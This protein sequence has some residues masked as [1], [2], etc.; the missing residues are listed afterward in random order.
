MND[1][2]EKLQNQAETFKQETKKKQ[3]DLL[4]KEKQIQQLSENCKNLERC[5][6]EFTKIRDEEQ[7]KSANSLEE[8]KVG[9][10]CAVLCS[11]RCTCTL[12]WLMQKE[13]G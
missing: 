10:L 8:I 6:A 11:D 4:A 5:I 1:Y 13:S 12:C 9:F 2:K 3:D 7:E